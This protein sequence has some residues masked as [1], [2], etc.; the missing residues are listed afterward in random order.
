LSENNSVM[1]SLADTE[2][3]PAQELPSNHL[4]R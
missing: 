3:H 1:L 2:F 4:P